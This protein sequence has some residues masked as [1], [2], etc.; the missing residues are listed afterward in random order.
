[1]EWQG[2]CCGRLH[3]RDNSKCTFLGFRFFFTPKSVDLQTGFWQVG[4][5]IKFSLVLD[6]AKEAKDAETLPENL[7]YLPKKAR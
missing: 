3:R 5:L 1:M 4:K 2:S 6:T 7:E